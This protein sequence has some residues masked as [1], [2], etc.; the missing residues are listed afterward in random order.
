MY[1]GYICLFTDRHQEFII[2]KQ[3]SDAWRAHEE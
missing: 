3:P 1:D 2:G